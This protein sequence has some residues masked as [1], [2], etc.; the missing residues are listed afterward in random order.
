MVVLN[1]GAAIYVGGLATD[2]ADGVAKAIEAIDSGAAERVL[3]RLI[4][5][6]VEL[7]D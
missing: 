5:T 3:E 6:S 2:L 1:A 7:T 4:A